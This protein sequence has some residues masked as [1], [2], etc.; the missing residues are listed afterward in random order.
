MELIEVLKQRRSI[1]EYTD[2]PLDRSTITHLIEAAILAPSAMNLQPW[3]FAVVLDGDRVEKYAE[4]AKEWLLLNSPHAV[5]DTSARRMFEDPKFAL[6]HHAP[7]LILILAKT[8]EAQAM[9]DCCLAA[10]NLLLAA[11]DQNVGTCWIGSAR[12]WLNLPSIK[13]ELSIPPA[14][15]VVA[16]IVVGYPRAWPESHGRKPPEIHWL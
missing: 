10:Q 16:P 11:R 1:R 12:P 4:R 15:E 7:A 3:A 8:P 5:S 13:A 2:K 9:E 14:Y 6:F